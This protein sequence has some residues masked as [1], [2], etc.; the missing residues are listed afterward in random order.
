MTLKQLPSGLAETRDSLHQLAFFALSPARYKAMGRM[1]LQGTPGG[2]GTPEFDGRVARI[3]G[4]QLVHSQDGNVATQAITTVRE[5]AE[6]FGNEYEA[7]W[8]ADFHDPLEASDPD[9]Q[10]LVSREASLAIGDWFEFG[11]AV[12]NELRSQGV[13]GDDVSEVQ[14]WPEHLDPAT[15]LGD[16]EKGQRASFGASP[17]DGANPEPYLYVASWSDVDRSD[18]YWNSTSFNGSS[19]AYE[20]L[21][22]SDDPHGKALEFLVEG[23]RILHAG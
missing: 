9:A 7:E 5:A 21:L 23:Y 6:F 16:Y 8:F 12:L 2:F 1:G 3:E 10:L 22:A 13:E 20:E 15:E 17:G 18:A 14:L 4:D 19:L 11:F